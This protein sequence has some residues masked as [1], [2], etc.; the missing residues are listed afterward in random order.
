MDSVQS[1]AATAF[2]DS[3]I[4]IYSLGKDTIIGH[5]HFNIIGNALIRGEC[6]VV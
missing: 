6:S 1:N 3:A 2:R 5:V 4:M